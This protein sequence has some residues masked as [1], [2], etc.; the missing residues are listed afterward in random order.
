MLNVVW[1]AVKLPRSRLPTDRPRSTTYAV[2]CVTGSHR[3]RRCERA[4][5]CANAMA[6]P[7]GTSVGAGA[8]PGAGPGPGEG[9]GPGG[10]AGVGAGDGGVGV[11]GFDESSSGGALGEAGASLVSAGADGATTGTPDVGSS[12]DGDSPVQPAVATARKPAATQ[13]AMSASRMTSCRGARTGP[14]EEPGAPRC[15]ATRSRADAC[16]QK[17]A[18]IHRP[19]PG[20]YKGVAYMSLLLRGFVP[21]R[22]TRA[23]AS[24]GISE[25]CAGTK[26]RFDD[27]SHRPLRC[28]S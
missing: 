15:R 16:A 27:R 14:L 25:V 21:V 8:D 2:A 12:G 24:R 18:R 23:G 28:A 22:G 1:P 13:R 9:V 17:V 4:P 5:S 3:T 19:A 6:K 10:G 26:F 11:G 7:V 20:T